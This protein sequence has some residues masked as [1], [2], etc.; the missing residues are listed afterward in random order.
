MLK[1]LLDIIISLI[2][3][4]LLFIPFLFVAVLI[5]LDSPGPVFFRQARVGKDGKVF[6]VFKLRTMVVDAEDR[7]KK[8]FKSV[9]FSS[10]YFQN[11]NDPRITMV[12]RFLRRGFD[13]LPQII[14]VLWGD[15][16]LAGP[17][18]EV[19]EIVAGYNE[20][21]KERLKVKPGITCLSILHGRGDL[22]TQQTLAYDLEY[23]KNISFLL[24]LKILFATLWVVLVTGRG[25]K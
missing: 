11:E 3:I 17:R 24:D 25:A 10:Y 16:S 6:K 8:D 7:W 13:E 5:K 15:M 21:E 4:I 2:G 23:V 18:P 1:R 9:D 19:P 22:T 20:Q 14:N 12:G